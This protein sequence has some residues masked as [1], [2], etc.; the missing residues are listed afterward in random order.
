MPGPSVF[1]WAGVTVVILRLTDLLCVLLVIPFHLR[2]QISQM[3]DYYSML[4]SKSRQT[5]LIKCS[6]MHILNLLN[7]LMLNLLNINEF[8]QIQPPGVLR[9]TPYENAQLYIR[10]R[11]VYSVVSTAMITVLEVNLT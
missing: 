5:V 6:I 3:S 11:H 1:I 2:F 8:V 9:K 7:V 4:L 10:N